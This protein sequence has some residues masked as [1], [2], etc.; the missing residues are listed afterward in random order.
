MRKQLYGFDLGRMFRPDRQP[1][2]VE[3]KTAVDTLVAEDLGNCLILS[4]WCF[5][6][7]PADFMNLVNICGKYGIDI[8]LMNTDRLKE[9]NYGLIE[10]IYSLPYCLGGIVG[11]RAGVLHWRRHIFVKGVPQSITDV[12]TQFREHYTEA[13]GKL[14]RH[15]AKA[16]A[17]MEVTP[18]GHKFA[19]VHLTSPSGVTGSI[20]DIMAADKAVLQMILEAVHMSEDW[21]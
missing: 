14:K 5:R 21:L 17:G 10:T 6:L 4:E 20:S 11:E 12:E 9:E 13:I 16:C 3:A 15:G 1:T 19:P 7:S 18:V 2:F 8:F